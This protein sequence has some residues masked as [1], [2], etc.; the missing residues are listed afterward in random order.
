MRSAAKKVPNEN[1]VHI[2][3]ALKCRNKIIFR[4]ASHACLTI[5]AK[6]VKKSLR[7]HRAAQMDKRL[8]SVATITCVY[9]HGV[10]DKAHGT[11]WQ[12]RKSI[13]YIR[14]QR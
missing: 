5:R 2:K 6:R 4:V 3:Q 1:I 14:L 9:S 7:S 13:N 12:L 10:P 11:N 8:R